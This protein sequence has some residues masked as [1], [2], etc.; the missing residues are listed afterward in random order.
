LPEE[1]RAKNLEGSQKTIP[2]IAKCVAN[3]NFWVQT[4]VEVSLNTP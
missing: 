4:E 1:Q 2:V 3:E